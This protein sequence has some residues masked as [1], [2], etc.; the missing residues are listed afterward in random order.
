MHQTDWQTP[1]TYPLLARLLCLTSYITFKWD[2]SQCY[3]GNKLKISRQGLGLSLII[4]S[5]ICVIIWCLVCLQK[6]KP[7]YLRMEWGEN[8]YGET[9][10]NWSN[11]FWLHSEVFTYS[12]QFV[13]F[14]IQDK[15]SS[16][17]WVALCFLGEMGRRSFCS[18]V[19]KHS[20]Y[21]ARFRDKFLG[22]YWIK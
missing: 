14:R 2:F 13:S 7:Q 18:S 11:S 12:L 4:K 20:F 9:Y 21:T 3:L 6:G 22:T 17:W 8:P 19:Q 10:P 1:D 16:G 15:M 5:F